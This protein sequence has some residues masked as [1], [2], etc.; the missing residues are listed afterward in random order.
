M[1][2][3]RDELSHGSQ[4]VGLS[5]AVRQVC[6]F[7]FEPHAFGDVPRNDHQSGRPRGAAQV[8][9]DHGKGAI[10]RGVGQLARRSRRRRTDQRITRQRVQLRPD[11]RG[12]QLPA[13]AAGFPC[14]TREGLIRLGHLQ[15]GIAHDDEIRNR[16]E[17]VFELAARTDHF[18]D[19][20]GVLERRRQLPPGGIGSLHEIGARAWVR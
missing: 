17:D 10:E 3:A 7:G 15:I 18:I 14:T 11:E 1:R 9:H 6:A 5:E 12:K 4:L 16:I 13:S 2:D 8:R 19:E 20:R